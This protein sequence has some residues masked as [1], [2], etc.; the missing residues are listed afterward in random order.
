MAMTDSGCISHDYITYFLLPGDY[1]RIAK[2]CCQ[3][4]GYS[5]SHAQA[6]SACLH[7]LEVRTDERLQEL[8]EAG[9][10]KEQINE[11]ALWL[12]IEW[13]RLSGCILDIFGANTLRQEFPKV[14]Q[15]GF[16][17]S[18]YVKRSAKGASVR[19]SRGEMLTYAT[20]EGARL[21]KSHPGKIVH[22]V[23]FLFQEVNREI[24]ERSGAGPQGLRKG[25]AAQ[26][27][28]TPTGSLDTS[29]E[30]PSEENKIVAQGGYLITNESSSDENIALPSKND[31]G[32]NSSVAQ[33]SQESPTSEEGGASW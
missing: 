9:I 25:E 6:F 17:R 5:L 31:K 4:S 26:H 2:M 1:L 15:A 23:L 33:N 10:G 24:R 13:H 32:S 7:A 19:D 20:Y 27:L 28:V 3:M 16:C 14:E 12:D 18:R 22:Q 29:A 21:D 8:R 11:E 30:Q